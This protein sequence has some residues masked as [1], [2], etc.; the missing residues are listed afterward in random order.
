M[1]NSR[2]FLLAID[3]ADKPG[4]FIRLQQAFPDLIIKDDPEGYIDISTPDCSCSSCTNQSDSE[5][6]EIR[7]LNYI[8]LDAKH[9]SI[10]S[11]ERIIL[12]ELN[13]ILWIEASVNYTRFHLIDG[14]QILANHSICNFEFI[15]PYP[16]FVRV[17]RSSI[18]NIHQIKEYVNAGYVIMK[19]KTEIE[20][21]LNH[22]KNLLELI[23]KLS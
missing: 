11:K 5:V 14:A 4:F 17:H 21:S 23:N 7:K 3:P 19:D 12:I 10:H 8:K 9:L 18:I 15:L 6:P 2:S 22:R 1:N 13:N 16:L 20:V